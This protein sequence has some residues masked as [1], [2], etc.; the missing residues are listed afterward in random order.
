MRP[1]PQNIVFFFT[2]VASATASPMRPRPQNIVF[3]LLQCH[4]LQP[5][6]CGHTHRT[7]FVF[8]LQCH[9]LQPV[10]CGHAHR[11]FFFYY[12]AICYSQSNAATP[13]EHCFRAPLPDQAMERFVCVLCASMNTFLEQRIIRQGV[14]HWF[15]GFCH[16]G[17]GCSYLGHHHSVS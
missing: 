11:T 12:S 5:V 17:G 10:Q 13:T 15:D 4:L 6:Q 8:L 7:L 16:M 9:L 14:K 3:F 2:T 1:R